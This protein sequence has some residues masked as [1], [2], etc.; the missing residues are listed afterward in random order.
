MRVGVSLVGN[1]SILIPPS[2][3]E[4]RWLTCEAGIGDLGELGE[5]RFEFFFQPSKG[6]ESS[7]SEN[8]F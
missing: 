3:G 8:V 2:A 5:D 1:G 6:R 4:R 7:S